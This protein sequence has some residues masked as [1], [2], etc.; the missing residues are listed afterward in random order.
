[1]K[2]LARMDFNR[3]LVLAD[4]TVF[5]GNGFGSNKEV[6]C[7][8][9]FHTGMTGYQEILTDPSYYEQIVVM[10]YPMI[11]NYGISSDDYQTSVGGASAL[12]VKEY[13]EVPSNWRSIKSL[14]EFL[15]ERDISGLCDVD[16]RALTIKIRNNGTTRGII[17]DTNVTDEDAVAKL[18]SAPTINDH[19]KRVSPTESYKIPV[20]NKKFRIVIMTFGAKVEGLINE[21]VNRDCEVIVVPYNVSAADISSLSP[22]GIILGNGPGSPSAIPEVLPVIKE[23]QAKYPLFGV[24]LGHQLFA[25][26]N[27]ATISKMKFGHHGRNFPVKD[28]ATNRTL[29]TSQNH[30]YQVEKSSLEGADLELTHFAI[31]DD[32]TE[33]IK[34]KKYPAFSVQFLP[35]THVGPQDS[36]DL[37]DQF[38][39][40]LRGDAKD[41]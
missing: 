35:E 1:M 21:L 25:L 38:V 9:I 15:K 33:G 5:L 14:D 31:N 7:D 28:I 37:F 10:T 22:D 19:V 4:G 2:E 40:S 34:H 11:G 8:I 26:A 13:C 6:V 41:G 23:L 36:K 24:S 18:N 17:V 27:G 12:I 3:K 29:I 39:E 32:T 30:L 20:K 16:T